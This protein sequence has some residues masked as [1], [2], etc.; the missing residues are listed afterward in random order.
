MSVVVQHLTSSYEVDM[1]AHSFENMARSLAD[2]RAGIV[3]QHEQRRQKVFDQEK[4]HTLVTRSR[5]DMLTSQLNPH[6]LFNALNTLGALSEE[7]PQEP[8]RLPIKVANVFH[9]TLKASERE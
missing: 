5:L 2:S 6:F 4:F 9:Q 1:L 3:Q 8:P 7:N